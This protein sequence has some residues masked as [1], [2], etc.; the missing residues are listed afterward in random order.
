MSIKEIEKEDKRLRTDIIKKLKEII[1]EL[2]FKIDHLENR[3]IAIRNISRAL[4]VFEKPRGKD[5]VF[6]HLKEDIKEQIIDAEPEHLIRCEDCDND[7]EFYVCISPVWMELEKG[8]NTILEI[9]GD[10]RIH[11]AD[12]VFII[13]R[14]CNKIIVESCMY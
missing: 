3:H 5:L 8:S 1:R 7:E 9:T 4:D 10:T 12:D 6:D 13:C 11:K 14:K 2:L